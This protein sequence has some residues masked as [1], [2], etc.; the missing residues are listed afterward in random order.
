MVRFQ[1]GPFRINTGSRRWHPPG[2]RAA[3]SLAAAR[4]RLALGRMPVYNRA[5]VNRQRA[6]V[7]LAGH[8]RRW[9]KPSPN[10]RRPF[11]SFSKRR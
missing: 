7:R 2:S 4:A 1:A 3:V 6:L 9:V 10:R 5:A 8:N 11:V